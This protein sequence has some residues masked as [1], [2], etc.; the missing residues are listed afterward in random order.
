MATVSQLI[1]DTLPRLVDTKPTGTT[2]YQAINYVSSMITR[3]MISRRSDLVRTDEM[4][5]TVTP[6]IQTYNLPDGFV[7]LAEKPFDAARRHDIE[8][9]QHHRSHY[10][11][12]TAHSPHAYELLGQQIIFYPALD[13][14]IT[15]VN[16]VGRYYALPDLITGPTQVVNAQT[17]DVNVPFNGMFDQAFFQ[18]VPRVIAKGLGVVQADGDFAAF[19]S[20]EVDTILN[21]RSEPLPQRRTSRRNFI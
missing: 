4:S 17:V 7:S 1:L 13:T 6:S 2:I 15:S 8:P 20:A 10:H 19:I 18:G 5:L 16:I 12:K 11:G 9:L 14:G 3:H 21:L